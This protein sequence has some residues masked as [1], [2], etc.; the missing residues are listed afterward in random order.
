MTRDSL[1][2]P[3][4]QR[5][6]SKKSVSASANSEAPG[7]RGQDL[8]D[9]ALQQ[10]C[11][12]GGRDHSQQVGIADDRVVDAEQDRAFREFFAV[13]KDLAAESHQTP[14]GVFVEANGKLRSERRQRLQPQRIDLRGSDEQAPT[15]YGFVDRDQAIRGEKPNVFT[16]TLGTGDRERVPFHAQ[17]EVRQFKQV[18]HQRPFHRLRF[19]EAVPQVNQIARPCGFDFQPVNFW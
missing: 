19:G 6:L 12:I 3:F 18:R 7:I 8:F 9:H 11:G 5:T 13:V 4:A 14:A 2:E 15:Q 16:K 1:S 17:P 10:A